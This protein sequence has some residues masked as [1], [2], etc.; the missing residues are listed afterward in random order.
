MCY[1]LNLTQANVNFVKDNF[2]KQIRALEKCFP[3]IDSTIKQGMPQES[4]SFGGGTALAIYYLGHRKSFD[5]DLFLND[6]QYLNYLNPRLWLDDYDGFS[7]EYIEQQSHIGFQTSDGIKIDILVRQNIGN[8]LLDDTNNIFSK[9]IHISSIEDIIA[10]KIVY[11]KND[12]KTRDIFD[13]VASL[14]KYPNLLKNLLDKE[15]ITISDLS[16]L[17]NALNTIDMNIYNNEIAIVEPNEEFKQLSFEAPQILIEKLD[18]IL[19]QKSI[20]KMR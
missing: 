15:A 18:K 12:N 16:D 19:G 10:N 20:R 4:I 13:I 14:Q 8:N 2:P 9:A 3:L 17:K 6:I 11:R 1:H 7:N 5:I